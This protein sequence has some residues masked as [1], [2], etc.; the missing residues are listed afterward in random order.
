MS[1]RTAHV[2]RAVLLR[3]IDGATGDESEALASLVGFERLETK[4]KPL[5]GT[6]EGIRVEEQPFV[7]PTEPKVQA[8][9]AIEL[10]TFWRVVAQQVQPE[11]EIVDDNV[12]LWWSSEEGT[13]PS[14]E[15]APINRR[16]GKISLLHWPR[17]LGFFRTHLIAEQPSQRLDERRFVRRISEAR[18]IRRIPRKT[19]RRWPRQVVLVIDRSEALYPLWRDYGRMR[20]QLTNLFGARLKVIHVVARRAPVKRDFQALLVD[21]ELTPEEAVKAHWLILSDAGAAER[22]S[23]RERYW[24][25]LLRWLNGIG[26][27]HPP[28]ALINAPA[29]RWWN[30]LGQLA[31][32]AF[33]DLDHPLRIS[34]GSEGGQHQADP[35][36]G[37]L[38]AMLS[39]TPEAGPGL[40]RELRCLL[41]SVSQDISWEIAAWNHP[42]VLCCLPECYVQSA[43]R[44]VHQ[45]RF[46]HYQDRA[47]HS[48]EWPH[49]ALEVIMTHLAGKPA[50]I[51]DQAKDWEQAA[52]RQTD[53]AA[54]YLVEV[55]N[56][57]L[58]LPA[59][60]ER[61]Q[62]ARWVEQVVDSTADYLIMAN[63]KL[64]ALL[65]MA[66]RERRMRGQA[67]PKL[68]PRFD[69][70]FARRPERECLLWQQG[71]GWCVKIE[72]EAEPAFSGSPIGALRSRNT[73]FEIRPDDGSIAAAGFWASGVAPDW[74]SDWGEDDYG[75]WV[76]F[77]I[78]YERGEPVTQRLRWIEPGQFSMGSPEDE[79]K[80]E[81]DETRHEVTLTQGFWL[82]DTSVTQALW[83]VVM[84]KKPSKHGGAERPVEQV[85]WEEVMTFTTRLNER[86]AGLGLRLPTEAE[87]EYACRAGTQ[88]PFW[89]GA[90]ITTAHVNYNGNHP[91]AGGEKGEY[92]QETVEV[93]ALPCNGWGLY[94]MHGN[95]WE[96]CN[97]WYREYPAESVT[98]PQGPESGEGRVLR[99][100]GWY[101]GGGDARSARRD[102]LAPG[103]RSL[104]TGF[105]LA[106]GQSSIQAG[107]RPASPG[108]GQVARSD[109]GQAP[110]DAWQRL[111]GIFK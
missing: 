102:S 21:A 66:Y 73:T 9:S 24:Q 51:R 36:I 38:L 55:I 92:R 29:S 76:E 40:L 74:A 43:K 23:E 98:D 60:S 46:L 93:K 44:P 107:S 10:P 28:L 7:P 88:T 35:D 16:T 101:D 106:R 75:P 41:P 17:L 95:V 84:A 86:V 63:E 39:M 37:K 70:I 96:W 61:D 90:N 104:D 5:I 58:D 12:P 64:G 50:F 30:G 20:G 2:S 109:A 81:S 68:D 47:K 100:G 79:P 4:R 67:T 99:G 80:R 31:K 3:L 82:A 105:R 52:K 6:A 19:Y 91:Y 14:T 71:D 53:D 22:N 56:A 32:T 48:G 34:H 26:L 27:A 77:R 87:W 78:E 59:G 54:G 89:F 111:K 72:G 1:S 49:R 15:T 13:D 103:Y 62:L 25:A 65:N 69:F 45:L 57:L 18:L 8:P 33:W 85:S 42:D 97:D 94:Q 110:E 108:D 83:E 11:R